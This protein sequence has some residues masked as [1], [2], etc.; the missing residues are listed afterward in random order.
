MWQFKQCQINGIV[1]Y[2]QS[3]QRLS[4]C[5]ESVTRLGF[6]SI[7]VSEQSTILAKS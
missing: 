2:S 1:H 7:T 6:K 3:Y 5:K 4:N